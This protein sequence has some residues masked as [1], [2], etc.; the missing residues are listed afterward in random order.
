MEAGMLWLIKKM[1][2]WWWPEPEW[3]L[4]ICGCF[5]ARGVETVYRVGKRGGGG[6]SAPCPQTQGAA[7]VF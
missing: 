1:Q 6:S 5:G 2:R 7:L 3:Q 4:S